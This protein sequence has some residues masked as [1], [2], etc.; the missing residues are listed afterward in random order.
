[1]IP[2]RLQL[3][4]QEFNL[5]QLRAP[6]SQVEYKLLDNEENNRQIGFPELTMNDL[7]YLSLG[8]YQ[9]KNAV[10]YYTEHQK[11][12]L[13]LVQK[14]N[15]NRRHPS[16]A[17]NYENYGISVQQPMLIKAYKSRYRG[18]KHHYIFVLIDKSKTSRD[19]ICEYYCTCESGARTAGCY[20]HVMTIVWYLGYAQYH[21]V[22]I[23]NPDVCNVSIT[24][25]KAKKT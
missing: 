6:F 12:G 5:S 4:V 22:N 1:M 7:Y 9:I 15:P 17:V 8:P 25:P 13:F 24:I 2:N 23:P 20:S 10:S 21:G 14:F 11:D 3:I 19:A 18:D 16:A